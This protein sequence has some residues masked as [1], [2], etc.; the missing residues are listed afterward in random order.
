M[1]IQRQMTNSD[2][3]WINGVFIFARRYFALKHIR[4]LTVK[5]V[6]WYNKNQKGHGKI[7][8]TSID[9]IVIH[10]YQYE[11]NAD[12]EAHRLMIEFNKTLKDRNGDNEAIKKYLHYVDILDGTIDAENQNELEEA[13]DIEDKIGSFFKSWV[14]YVWKSQEENVKREIF[15]RE[16][17]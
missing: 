6:V 5:D 14:V 12:D 1:F 3:V 4:P 17:D 10:H 7:P 2:R 9:D 15:E 16:T 8:L 11:K 13:F